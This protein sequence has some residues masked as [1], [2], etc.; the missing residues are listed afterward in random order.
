M[1]PTMALSRTNTDLFTHGLVPK[2]KLAP[3]AESIHDKH[4]EAKI[5][6]NKFV[7]ARYKDGSSGYSE[8]GVL[9]VCWSDDDLGVTDE[10][11]LLKEVFGEQFRF[12]TEVYKIPKENSA[13]KLQARMQLWANQYEGADKLS[14]I[15]YAGH[16]SQVNGNSGQLELHGTRE[17]P[18]EKAETFFKSSFRPLDMTDTDTLLILD[19]CHAA[20]SFS[21]KQIGRRKFELLC[22]VAPSETAY[23]PKNAASFTKT[24]YMAL[25]DL[26]A[27]RPLQG[28]ST[29]ELYMKLYHKSL[30]TKKPFLFDQSSKNFGWIYLRPFY[31]GPEPKQENIAVELRLEMSRMPE[32]PEMKE[33][34]AHMQYLP[35]VKKLKFQ[36]LHAPDHILD[37]FFNDL[38]RRQR[39]RPFIRKLRQRVA[40]KRDEESNVPP[41][42]ENK[43]VAVSDVQD[44]YD[45]GAETEMSHPNRP[46]RRAS[47]PL[48]KKSLSRQTTAVDSNANDDNCIEEE[49]ASL[50]TG[51]NLS[52]AMMFNLLGTSLSRARCKYAELSPI[53]FLLELFVTVLIFFLEMMLRWCN[54]IHEWTRQPRKL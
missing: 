2:F 50:K 6:F 31:Y 10:V 52:C 23:G 53:K 34:A 19:C 15:Y 33:L 49:R 40:M 46:V 16:G 44:I 51:N 29:S 30:M 37:E 47:M 39:I 36:H 13:S 43:K 4:D 27:E 42:K 32:E 18:K 28:F 1:S 11:N 9:L 24:L 25:M 5:A 21:Q 48:Y 20:L 35:L 8:V 14:I 17:T 41:T 45:W 12:D 7:D 54:G 38:I 3:K 26:L 22:S